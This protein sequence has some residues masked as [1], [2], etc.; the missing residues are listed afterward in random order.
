MGPLRGGFI[1]VLTY[2]GLSKICFPPMRCYGECFVQ[3]VAT[4]YFDL[5]PLAS[6][7]ASGKKSCSEELSFVVVFLRFALDCLFF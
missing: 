5:N 6:D 4:L 1:L 3:L 7:T 2:L